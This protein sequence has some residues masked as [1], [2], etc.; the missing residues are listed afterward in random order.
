MVHCPGVHHRVDHGSHP[1][2]HGGRRRSGLP[3]HFGGKL[4]CFVQKNACAEREKEG[5][6]RQGPQC[7]GW[8][9]MCVSTLQLMIMTRDSCCA[10]RSRLSSFPLLATKKWK[11][12]RWKNALVLVVGTCVF[13]RAQPPAPNSKNT[14]KL[15]GKVVSRIYG[16][17]SGQ[18]DTW[19]TNATKQEVRDSHASD[20]RNSTT[21]GLSLPSDRRTQHI[22]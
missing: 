18:H 5:Q 12:E 13:G 8:L 1:H 22:S 7:L 10:L 2:Q 21:M 15:S 16:S 3:N 17:E 20:V 9:M 14:L 4:S 11:K 19:N 6:S